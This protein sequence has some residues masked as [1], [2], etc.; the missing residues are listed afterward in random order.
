MARAMAITREILIDIETL[1]KN[2]VEKKLMFSSLHF[3]H[4]AFPQI[5]RKKKHKKNGLSYAVQTEN[6][7]NNNDKKNINIF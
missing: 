5:I 4:L 7:N 3:K 2:K 6:N 1:F